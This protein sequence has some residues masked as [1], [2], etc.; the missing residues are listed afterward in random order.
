MAI[1]ADLSKFKAP[2][3]KMLTK[4]NNNSPQ[5]TP[6]SGARILIIN[7]RKGLVNNPVLVGDYKREYLSLFDGQSEADFRKGN[8]GALAAEEMLLVSPIWVLNLRSFD[9]QIDQIGKVKIQCGSST[10]ND[11]NGVGERMPYRR[12][13]NTQQFW[14][15]DASKLIPNT[16]T[17]KSLL[18]IGNVGSS[19]LSIIVRKTKSIQRDL[20]FAQWY[21]N[22]NR[23]MPPYLLPTDKISDWMVDVVIFD[24]TFNADSKSN[25]NYGYCFDDNGF[26][27]KH[28][29]S[30]AS[31]SLVD[32]LQELS[33]LPSSGY[34]RTITGSLIENFTDESGNSLDIMKLINGSVQELGLV[35]KLD[36]ELFD[37]ASVWESSNTNKS[38]GNKKPTP[39]DFVGH[40]IFHT[41]S[42]GFIDD[43]IFF[44]ED[45]LKVMTLD[46]VS[47][48][49]TY[50]LGEFGVGN[51]TFDNN[52]KPKMTQLVNR[53]N[54]FLVGDVNDG[55]TI[56]SPKGLDEL[57]VIGDW[58]IDNGDKWA[59]VDANLASVT[60]VRYVGKTTKVWGV[61]TV[62]LPIMPFGLS[63]GGRNWA[64][65]I[66]GAS[67]YTYGASGTVFPK[68]GQSGYF[69]YPPTHP[70][71]GEPLAFDAKSGQVV[72]NPSL[73]NNDNYSWQKTNNGSLIK[74][75]WVGVDGGYVAGTEQLIEFK[76]VAKDLFEEAD[77]TSFVETYGVE[78][79]VYV[80][81]F[82]K[83]LAF[84]QEPKSTVDADVAFVFDDHVIELSDG[85]RITVYD[86]ALKA[87]KVED[88]D[89]FVD[90]YQP[91][92]VKAYVP[93]TEQ[94]LNGTFERQ[95]SVLDVLMDA[96]MVK[97]LSNR[98]LIQW[99]YIVDAF[100][101]YISPNAKHQLKG[102][103]QKRVTG[104]AILNM[105]SVYDFA[106]STDPYFSATIG[107]DFDA[108]YI[109]TGG[110][111]KLPHNNM[112]TLPSH[113]GWYAYFYGSNLK[114][115]SGRTFPPAATV[116][117]SFA[118]KYKNGKPY[119]IVAGEDDGRLLSINATGLEHIFSE[120]NDGDG[121]LDHLYPFG[122]NALTTTEIG[123][124]IQIF[125][126]H[127]AFNTVS[128]PM[129]AI[130]TSEVVM[131]IQEQI[132]SLLKRYVF[133]YNTANNRL[134]VR[135]VADNIC[136]P[137]RDAGAIS[138]YTN[139]IDLL[140][141]TESIRNNRIGI[142][143]TRL[144]DSN[145]MEILVHRTTI[146]GETNTASFEIL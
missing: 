142:L 31:N 107:G 17:H 38:D 96:S 39:V 87:Y 67:T 10:E 136:Q 5:A 118:L 15:V 9:D 35:A 117:N 53:H 114:M 131:Y 41:D 63:D 105:P 89:K 52:K 33:T 74:I 82:D 97:S 66:G 25:P 16:S 2:G 14:R 79:N 69:V 137:A 115:A 36:D 64:D 94:F 104:R 61:G 65:G 72:H 130:H 106:N 62:E 75:D 100:K 143:D 60:G 90:S 77:F 84:S 98:K 102:I 124:D 3:V 93:R 73:A 47:Y 113:E 29:V 45:E 76:H 133:K 37:V 119:V 103:A 18:N 112:F 111:K 127:T 20:T 12:I 71:A 40:E 88:F 57:V 78:E 68:N 81:K 43:S 141:N 134:R 26:V 23:E 58:N 56:V 4:V 144:V 28:V 7:S 34:I 1:N 92:S 139:Q 125:G 140:N 22:L 49:K 101:T 51:K 91:F 42:D 122:Y 48:K 6:P 70:L 116:S 30:E 83:P 121:D 109:S 132:N 24:N 8:F 108:K 27:K 146:D 123:G 46:D 59:G 21:T 85:K 80:V 135:E 54:A 32:G 145:G 86:N 19:D 128:S 13:H 95:E 99:N 50:T 129:G 126:N 55:G 138:D 110:N 11:E 44:L 120:T